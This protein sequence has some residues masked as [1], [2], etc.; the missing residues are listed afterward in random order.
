MAAG[1]APEARAGGGG[2]QAT[3]TTLKQLGPLLRA[4]EIND[5]LQTLVDDRN[6]IYGEFLHALT[7]RIV[8]N[9]PRGTQEA[10][11]A[12]HTGHVS[13]GLAWS[14]HLVDPILQQ[15]SERLPHG[16]RQL[17]PVYLEPD[18]C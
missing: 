2:Y 14:P 11:A 17:F 12:A 9:G 7:K 3:K 16:R 6:V 1:M 10:S 4:D 18:S 13:M 8:R 15:P 5:L